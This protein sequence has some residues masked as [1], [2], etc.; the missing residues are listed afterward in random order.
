VAPWTDPAFAA[1][2]LLGCSALMRHDIGVA[3]GLLRARRRP[4]KA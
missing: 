3:F 4:S 2:F 1:V